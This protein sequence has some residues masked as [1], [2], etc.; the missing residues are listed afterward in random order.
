MAQKIIFHTCW[1]VQGGT[2]RLSRDF[3]PVCFHCYSYSCDNHPSDRSSFKKLLQDFHQDPNELFIWYELRMIYLFYDVV[4]LV[5]NIRNDL[6]NYKRFVFF[7][8][9]LVVNG[10]Q[11]PSFLWIITAE[12]PVDLVI[13]TEEIVNGKLHFFWSVWLNGFKHGK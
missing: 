8:Q 13:F 12:F 10:D 9:V 1:L 5:K 2:Y 3:V 11:K 7:I 4:Y 6:L